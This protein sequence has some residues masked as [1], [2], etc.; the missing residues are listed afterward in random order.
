VLY[1]IDA[2]VA[3]KWLLPEPLSDRADRLLQAFRRGRLRLVAPDLLIPEVGNALWK[4]SV[5]IGEIT[6]DEARLQYRRLLGLRL[7][8]VASSSL[9]TA[10]LQL[11]KQHAHPIYDAFYIALA[12]R[13]RC[14]LVTADEALLNKL[15]SPMLRWLGSV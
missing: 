13:R 11:A 2:S 8:L 12:V 10:A 3:V 1:V 14:D 15:R 9:A 4:R 5:R 6:F 7:P